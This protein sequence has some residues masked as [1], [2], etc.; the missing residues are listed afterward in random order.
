MV[1]LSVNGRRVQVD[2][3]F[4][5][6]TPEQQEATVNEIAAS[7]GSGET[8]NPSSAEPSWG[9]TAM[10]VGASLVSGVGRGVAGLAGLPGTVQDLANSGLSWAT[11]LP[12]LPR[13]P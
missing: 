1:T 9:D 6:M 8:D 7:M 13:S 3:S 10:D 12:E 4:R 2:D 5:N 11:G